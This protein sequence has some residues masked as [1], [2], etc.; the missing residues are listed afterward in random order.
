MSN[1]SR[2]RR[3]LATAACAGAVAL[4][5]MAGTA[6]AASAST[7]ASSKASGTC[8]DTANNLGGSFFCGGAYGPTG[9]EWYYFPDGVQEVF[10]IGTDHAMWTRWTNGSGNWVGWTSM[11]G[12]C[13]SLSDIPYA[14]YTPT[15]TVAGS[16]GNPWA[17]Q[18]QSDGHWTAWYRVN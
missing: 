9:E 1:R 12:S 6:S 17:K 14:G 16:D 7:S 10:V 13:W 2:T 11:G 18:R 15:V 5:A 3:L 4:G 8:T